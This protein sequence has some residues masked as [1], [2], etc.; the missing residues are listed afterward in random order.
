MTFKKIQ[1]RL[2]SKIDPLFLQILLP[3]IQK[4]IWHGILSAL[5]AIAT[6]VFV[7]L[8]AQREIV[9]LQT[10][11]DIPSALIVFLTL[12]C[13]GVLISGLSTWYVINKYLK[14]RLDDLY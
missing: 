1:K 8:L 14:M 5:I 3:Y 4:S 13:L 10:L 12:L 11:Q 7:L 2:V 6:L 9:E